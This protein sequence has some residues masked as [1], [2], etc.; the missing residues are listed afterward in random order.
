MNLLSFGSV[1]GYKLVTATF[2]LENIILK[3]HKIGVICSLSFR[4]VLER[5]EPISGS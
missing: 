2:M 4:S 5:R 1:T 3:I